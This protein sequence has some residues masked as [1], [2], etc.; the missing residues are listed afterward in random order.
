MNSLLQLEKV[1]KYFPVRSGFF[2]RVK[3]HVRAVDSVDLSIQKGQTLGL[4]GESGCGKTTVGRVI[5][6]L[7][8]ED[9]GYIFFDS[10][11]MTQLS[12]K[13]L[14]SVRS[15]LQ[16]IFQDPYSSLNPRM[17]VGEIIAEPLLIHGHITRRGR[18][19]K[20]GDLL[21][22]VG[23]DPNYYDR[24]PHEFSGGQRQRIGIARAIALSP[25]LIVADEAVSALDVSIAAQIVQLLKDLQRDMGIA[26]LFIAHDLPLVQNISHQVSVMYLGKIVEQGPS[27]AL[28][29]P[30][31]PYTEALIE[32]VPVPD[33]E[34]KRKRIILKGEV[35]SPLN[36]PPACRFHP[37]CPY[38]EPICKMEEPPLQEWQPGHFAACH[39]A[40]KVYEGMK[41]RSQNA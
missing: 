37:R 9:C 11:D 5:V 35:P 16:M 17:S 33:P 34:R 27:E 29:R 40:D 14:R 36:P 30:L 38:V 8:R 10:H 7:L 2:S 22:R 39:F 21:S 20:V 41:S 1:K 32:A 24:F 25:K 18:R 31:H 3:A 6:R 15:N 26:F 23:L 19:A 13:E 12:G 28:I 4:V